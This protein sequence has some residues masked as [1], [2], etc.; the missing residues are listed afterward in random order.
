M[1]IRISHFSS[2][3]EGEKKQLISDDSTTEN[4][5]TYSVKS[6][7]LLNVEAGDFVLMVILVSFD[8]AVSRGLS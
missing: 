8:L 7:F 5:H 6:I 3:H 2:P 1:M 4:N